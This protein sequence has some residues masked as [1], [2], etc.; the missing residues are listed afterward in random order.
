MLGPRLY[1]EKLGSLFAFFTGFRGNPAYNT[2]FM[3]LMLIFSPE[4]ALL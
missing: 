4:T 1:S 3:H 2:L